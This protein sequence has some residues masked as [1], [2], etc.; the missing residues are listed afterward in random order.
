MHLGYNNVVWEATSGILAD[1]LSVPGTIN[2]TGLSNL[3]WTADDIAL[4]LVGRGVYL[5][6]DGK[7]S[8]SQE[9][10]SSGEAAYGIII[11]VQNAGVA[12]GVG[13]GGLAEEPQYVPGTLLSIGVSGI[14]N[15]ALAYTAINNV[16][17]PVV[18]ANNGMWTPATGTGY[19]PKRCSVTQVTNVTNPARFMML[20]R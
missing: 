17:Q 14:W 7:F 16:M 9:S 10:L 5:R 13:G 19:D 15:F 18:T 6:N 8:I 3:A 1:D 12:L 20:M 4:G 11:K 2:R